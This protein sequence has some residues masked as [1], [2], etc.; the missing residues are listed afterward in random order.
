[1]NAK[2]FTFDAALVPLVLDGR[3]TQSRRL[4]RKFKAGEA[5]F[6]RSSEGAEYDDRLFEVINVWQEKVDEIALVDIKAEGIRIVSDTRL[7]RLNIPGRCAE[8]LLS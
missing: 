2:P 6:V 5:F 3:K 8:T 7:A 1:M 4:D